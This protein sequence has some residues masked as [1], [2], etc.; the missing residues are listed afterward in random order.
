MNRACNHCGA[1]YSRPF[2][3]LGSFC[4]PKCAYAART[5]R[6][7]SVRRLRYLPSHPLAGSTG[8][9]SAARAILYERL[10]PG[11]HHC[12]WCSGGIRWLRGHQGNNTRA[13]LADHLDS[14]PLNDAPENIV[15]A[16]GRCNGSRTQS[17]KDNEPHI[18]RPSGTRVR[19]VAR[20]CEACGTAF[21]VVRAELNSGRGRF[22]SRSCARRKRNA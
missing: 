21:L 16:C 2:S 1:T 5:K 9:L 10:G 15:P 20:N 12:H 22:C 13:I 14:N 8:L 7:T 17:V 19:A 3:Q 6:R 11:W 4:S 18:V